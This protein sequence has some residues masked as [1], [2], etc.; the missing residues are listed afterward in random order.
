M[1]LKVS[2]VISTYNHVTYIRRAMDSVLMQ[3]HDFEMEILVGEDESSDGTREI[4]LAYAE[5]YPD[6]IKPILH[7]RA[8]VIRINGKPT[9]RWNVMDT[10]RQAEGKYV[11][12]LEGDDYWL[13]PTKLKRQVQILEGN[14]RYALV[15]HAVREDVQETGEI[16]RIRKPAGKKRIYTRSDL[17]RRNF[18]A[19]GSVVFRN[20]LFGEFPTWFKETPMG[21]LPLNLL[22]AEHGDCAYL[23][24]VLGVYSLNTDGVWSTLTKRGMFENILLA[25]EV[26]EK[27]FPNAALIRAGSFY[28]R[29]RLALF[30]RQ[31]LSALT[32]LMKIIFTQPFFLSWRV[33]VFFANLLERKQA[34]EVPVYYV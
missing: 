4:V 11:A 12:F 3:E 17:M 29:F 13:S 19:A 27:A 23:D 6:L 33:E 22:N 8:D 18:I 5:K 34:G 28:A 9:G 10:L 16:L 25:Y 24:E 20:H 2:V 21:D 7:R 26:F 32:F 31:Y 30:D 15:F 1:S 14:P